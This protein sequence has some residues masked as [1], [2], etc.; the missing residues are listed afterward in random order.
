M[1][2]FSQNA[3]NDGVNKRN[4]SSQ[5]KRYIGLDAIITHPFGSS[6]IALAALDNPPI[7]RFNPL[8]SAG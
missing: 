5:F 7:A 6:V 3:I 4:S 8:A 2:G 1:A